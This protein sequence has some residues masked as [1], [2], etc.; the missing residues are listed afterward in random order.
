[1]T[2]VCNWRETTYHGQIANLTHYLFK[3]SEPSCDNVSW[4]K[5]S[6]VPG[7][8]WSTCR[9]RFKKVSVHA[10]MTFVCW[11]PHGLFVN[12]SESQE[13]NN[14]C[15]WYNVSA[16]HFNRTQ[17][18]VW[19]QSDELLNWYNGGPVLGT[20]HWH[21]LK[22]PAC[23]SR[24]SISYAYAYVSIPQNYTI[25]YNYTGY[26]HVCVNA[27]YL[28]AIGQFRNSTECRLYTCL[29]QSVP[30][31][32]TKDSVFLVQQRTD[33]W[34]PV[35]ISEPWSDSTLLSFVLKESLKRSKCFIGWIIAAIVGII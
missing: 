32:A 1:M 16:P 6:S 18:G 2:F 35:K 4:K 28:F 27:P 13:N 34:V 9:G 24:F 31:N 22:I 3:P 17:T 10:N 33:L 20:E 7:M 30:I 14:T 23:L 19:H 5:K 25:E 12:F 21:L 29:N 26:V 15:Q 11:G 8:D